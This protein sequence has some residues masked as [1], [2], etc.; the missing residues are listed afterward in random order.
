[1]ADADLVVIEAVL[2]GDVDRYAE[3]VNKYQGQTLRLAFSLLGN[4][5]D[6]RDVSQE[7]FVNAYRALNRFRRGAKFSTWLYRIV[8][9]ECQDASRRRFRQPVTSLGIGEPDPAERDGAALFIDVA[10]PAAGPAEQLADRECS[11]QLSRAIAALPLQQRTAFLLHHVH[12]LPLAEAAGIMGCRL[13]TV[14]AHI[15]R[16]T[17]RLQAFLRPW[18]AENKNHRTKEGR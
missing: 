6:A 15:F 1:M 13:G 9:N 2:A 17:G 10:D 5:E 12:G 3:L 16:A 8:V 4:D 7:A 14:K 11:R 18:L